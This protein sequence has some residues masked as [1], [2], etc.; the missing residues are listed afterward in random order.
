MKYVALITGTSS[1]FGKAIANYLHK[2]GIRVY[3]TSRRP[4]TAD[5]VPYETLALDIRN[6]GQI[7]SAV[8]HI[9]EKESS[10]DLL[11]NNAGMG[12]AGAAEMMSVEEMR[13]QFDVNFFGTVEIT[14]AV[15]EVMRSQRKG[16]IININSLAGLMAIPWQSAYCASKF[17]L[18]GYM[19][20][21]R[22][23]IMRWDIKI[24]DIHPGDFKTGFTAARKLTEQSLKEE[25]HYHEIFARALKTIET[26]ERNGADPE[27]MAKLVWRIVKSNRPKQQYTAGSFEQKAVAAIKPFI[28]GSLFCKIINGH[29][30]GQV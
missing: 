16:K 21:L 20:S 29:Y 10:I 2:Q 5:P 4:E 1:G 6:S 17:A 26:D 11:V 3:G 13:K 30:N 12:Y 14:K 19:E 27:K 9:I 25:S 28:P 18:K 24:S 23:E 15:V 8:A 22:M 7:K